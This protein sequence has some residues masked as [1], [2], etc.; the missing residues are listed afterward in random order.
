MEHGL[1]TSIASSEGG[2]RDSGDRIVERRL[3]HLLRLNAEVAKRKSLFKN[4]A[5]R[6]KASLMTRPITSQQAFGSFGMMIGSVPPLVAVVKVSISDGIDPTGILLLIVAAGM[7]AG[8][9]GLQFGRSYVP[10]AMRYIST[11]SILNRVALWSVLGLVWGT[12]SGAAGGLVVFLF[13]SIVGAVLGGIVGAV[14]VPIIAALFSSVRVGDFIET[15]HFRPIAFGVT[16]SV[17]AFLVGL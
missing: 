2:S 16:F 3:E 11:F 14:T 15:K 6:R 12:V 9:V 4:E 5:E 10:G 13:G 17:C 8:V 7:V 1:Y